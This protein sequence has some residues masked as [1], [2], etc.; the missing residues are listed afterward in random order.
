[1]SKLHRDIKNTNQ[2]KIKK[3]VTANSIKIHF[4]MLVIY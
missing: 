2:I 4:K 1:M 3:Y